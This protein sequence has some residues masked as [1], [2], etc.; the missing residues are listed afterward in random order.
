LKTIIPL[1]LF[2]LLS[3]SITQDGGSWDI[4]YRFRYY[5]PRVYIYPR[6]V[7]ITISSLVSNS[8]VP[9]HGVPLP[10][11]LH[12]DN[13]L[14]LWTY[15]NII[16]PEITGTYRSLEKICN[17]NLGISVDPSSLRTGDT[18]TLKLRLE[19]D[20]SVYKD[21]DPLLGTRFLKI[22]MKSFRF[23]DIIPLNSVSP[24]FYKSISPDSPPEKKSKKYYVSSP[25]S[26]YVNLSDE[27]SGNWY[28]EWRFDRM[29]PGTRWRLKFFYLIAL[30]TNGNPNIRI[31]Q[32]YQTTRYGENVS[33]HEESLKS[34]GRWTEY[35]RVIELGPLTNAL[36]LYIG[37]NSV[38]GVRE[39]V[40]ESGE[41]WVDD[42]T[43]SP[44]AHKLV[45]VGP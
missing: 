15:S 41:M 1:I 25:D 39:A 34:V 29:P 42:V 32:N 28:H 6:D 17:E 18:L 5:G 36:R 44:L 12:L 37:I 13:S 4:V 43:I 22:S 26:L 14:A 21:F 27:T 45:K 33:R 30:G 2:S 11:H 19:H 7:N 40:G 35:D 24:V 23:I 16:I 10:S 38:P 9:G 20:H 8:R 3:R 31:D